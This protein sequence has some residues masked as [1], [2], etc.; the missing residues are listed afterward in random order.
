MD[1][2]TRFSGLPE[3]EYKTRVNTV[4]DWLRASSY[5]G[6]LAVSGYAERD[7]NVCYL[8]GHKNAFPYSTKAE[9]I[10][11]L[12]YSALLLPTEGKTTLIAPLGYQPSAVVGVDNGKTGTNLARDLVEAIKQANLTDSRL[13]IAGGD[14]LPAVY[15]DEV[16]RLLPGLRIE[17]WDELAKMRMIKSE[18]ELGLIR[19]A[20][21]IADKAMTAAIESIKLGMKESAIGSVAR[22]AAMEA[23]ADYVVRD[24][25]Q[26][27]SEMGHLRW[28]FASSRKVRRGELVS[29]DFV[30]WVKSYG[31]DILRIGCAGRPNKDQRR[32]IETAGEAT[33][34]MSEKLRDQGEVEASLSVL[35]EFEK[36]GVHVEPFGHGIGLEIV[37][38]PYL[39]PGVTG[40]VRKNMVFCVEPDI[41]W[42]GGWASIENEVIVTSRRPEI[43]TKLPVYPS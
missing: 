35:R 3:Q 37:E 1:L 9:Q 21:K 23:G 17:Y 12:G 40:K 13:A 24:R 4:R 28:P 7:G 22:S 43:L 2:P 14:I 26:S 36:D 15:M 39:F 16:R 31:F 38:E 25:V 33:E 20:S 6:L 42:K 29:I 10:S 27:G 41:R 8:C 18:N 5:G 30:G 32:L 19:Q 11:G 34:A